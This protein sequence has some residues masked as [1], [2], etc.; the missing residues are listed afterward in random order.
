[1]R[2]GQAVQLPAWWEDFYLIKLKA[3]GIER[4]PLEEVGGEKD[5]GWEG[6]SIGWSVLVLEL[7]GSHE[8]WSPS[9]G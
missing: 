3:P 4:F 6:G 2:L 1:M 5:L 7:S 9:W 8:A